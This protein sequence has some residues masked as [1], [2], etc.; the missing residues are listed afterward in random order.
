MLKHPLFSERVD[1]INKIRDICKGEKAVKD[2]REEYLPKLETQ[3][4]KDY[5][6][7][8]KTSRFFEAARR[9]LSAYVGMIFRKTPIFSG[10]ETFGEQLD[11]L[12]IRGKTFETLAREIVSN[13][14]QVG[15]HCIFLDYPV[16]TMEYRS[17]LDSEAI[18]TLPKL[19]SYKIEQIT[20]WNYNEEKQL[21]LLILNTRSLERIDR[22][23]HSTIERYIVLELRDGY[24][25]KEVFTKYP[26]RDWESLAGFPQVR[27]QRLD[28]IPVFLADSLD[29]D[30]IDNS[31]MNPLIPPSLA[32]YQLTALKYLGI[33][34]IPLATPYAFGKGAVSMLPKRLSDN[35]PYFPLGSNIA[36][37]SEDPNMQVG[38]LSYSGDGLE[39]LETDMLALR[40]EMAAVGSRALTSEKKQVE[41]AETVRL[42]RTGENATLA[43]ISILS[44]HLLSNVLVEC[45]NLSSGKEDDSISYELNVDFFPEDIDSGKI[46]AIVKAWQDHAL[47]QR[48]M[49]DYFQQGEI[50][51]REQTFEEYVDDI[52]ED[53]TESNQRLIENQKLMQEAFNDNQQQ[54]SDNSN[55]DASGNNQQQDG[56]NS[57]QDARVTSANNFTKQINK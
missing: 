35:I 34:L 54:P 31:I 20:N 56:S 29:E 8:L 11:T 48:N 12:D 3:E 33:K 22:F 7:Y 28:H 27:G 49:F 47:S 26:E 23:Q 10:S 57:N 5:E 53:R 15:N 38:F 52:E 43:T 37:A 18:S 42:H 9:T 55:Q 51:P 21:D 16:D 6:E 46:T 24:Y 2:K 50:I 44:S 40:D 39:R 25:F 1:R 14:S 13:V 32:H 19:H 41:S 36:L 4:P 45:N 30:Y 17:L